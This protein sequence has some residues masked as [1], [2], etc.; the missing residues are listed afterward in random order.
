[1][2][3]HPVIQYNTASLKGQWPI[4]AKSRIEAMRK[5]IRTR[6]RKVIGLDGD[7]PPELWRYAIGRSERNED[8]S[9]DPAAQ[10]CAQSLRATDPSFGGDPAAYNQFRDTLGAPTLRETALRLACRFQDDVLLAK[11]LGTLLEIHH[12]GPI[13]QA[14]W[15]EVDVATPKEA[16]ILIQSWIQE[17]VGNLLGSLCFFSDLALAKM[18]YWLRGDCK[19]WLP[20][21]RLDAEPE[22]VKKLYRALGLIPAKPRAVKDV[23]LRA[24]MLHFKPFKKATCKPGR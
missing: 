18:L 3:G 22:R 10:A 6:H 8:L 21:D 13:P 4:I 16:Q 2:S 9:D 19:K 11:H 12:K 24:G 23:Y 20:P 14:R 15:R 5:L 7:S 1:M 17:P